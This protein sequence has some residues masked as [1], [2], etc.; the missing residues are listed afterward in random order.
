MCRANRSRVG[1]LRKSRDRD[2]PP[3]IRSLHVAYVIL[4]PYT[5]VISSDEVVSIR[6]LRHPITFPYRTL[7][8]G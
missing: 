1:S 4:V 6:D 8:A 7:A 3:C 2:H 5:A